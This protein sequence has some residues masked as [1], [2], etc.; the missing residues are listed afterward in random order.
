MQCICM[1][2]HCY[3]VGPVQCVCSALSRSLLDRRSVCQH[4]VLLFMGFLPQIIIVVHHIDTPVIIM[5][6]LVT[7]IIFTNILCRYGQD[8]C[9]KAGSR[10]TAKGDPPEVPCWTEGVDAR[11]LR[12]QLPALDCPHQNQGEQR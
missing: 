5:D 6:I 1:L 11:V 9:G 7:V 10:S 3:C 12:P 2:L 4:V 8:R